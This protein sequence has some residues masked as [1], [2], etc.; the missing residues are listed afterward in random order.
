MSVQVVARL[1]HSL[2][3]ELIRAESLRAMRE[4]PN[5]PEAMDLALHGAA[6]LMSNNVNNSA[7]NEAITLNERALVLDPQNVIAKVD[8]AIALTLRAQNSWSEDRSADIARADELTDDALAIYPDDTWAHY[9]KGW[10]FAIKH[11]WA[12]ALTETEMAI[13]DDR[14][15]AKAY[16]HAA[17][18]KILLGRSAES[19]ADVETAL[20]LSPHDSDA[21]LW[22]AF[23]CYG[24]TNSAQWDKAIEQCE[25]AV[26]A[27][28]EDWFEHI[29][30]LADLAAAYAWAGHDKEAKDTLAKLSKLHPNCMQS[31]QSVLDAS[32]DP[33][34]KA[35]VARIMEG[36]RK[37]DVTERQ[38]KSN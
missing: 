11:Q 30:A 35:D 16:G 9:T 23:L 33:K 25:K 2:Q 6:I 7:C 10:L 19:F 15:N 13:E 26:A 3:V 34:F 29:F 32:D 1:A 20:R 38:T 27:V 17:I 37:L 8:L 36:L 18:Y 22:Q 12:S 24:R 4:R 14:S 5:N 31:Y 28:P 21:R